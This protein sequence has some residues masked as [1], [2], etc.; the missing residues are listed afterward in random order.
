MLLVNTL[1]AD[2]FV[3]FHKC[4]LPKDVTM[5]RMEGQWGSSIF[6]SVSNAPYL[7]TV[8]TECASLVPKGKVHTPSN[9]CKAALK[10]FKFEE[11]TKK[12]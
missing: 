5:Q 10:R 3:E 1:S 6:S 9:R 2:A 7:P 12:I 4:S 8:T 11:L